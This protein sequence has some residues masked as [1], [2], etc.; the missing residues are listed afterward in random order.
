MNYY[1]GNQRFIIEA[2]I[3]FRTNGSY[4]YLLLQRSVSLLCPEFIYGF[5]I[6]LRINSCYFPNSINQMI[7]VMI[8][9][10]V[11][12]GGKDWILKYYSEG[13]GF[14]G[15]FVSLNPSKGSADTCWK[16]EYVGRYKKYISALK[17]EAVYFFETLIC[18]LK[19]TGRYYPEDQHRQRH[20]RQNLTSHTYRYIGSLIS[21]LSLGW[22]QVL[23]ATSMNISI[24][25]DV[26]PWWWMLF[27]IVSQYL[28]DYMAQHPRRQPSSFRCLCL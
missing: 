24:F 6:N 17:T 22:L 8:I 7:F 18:T 21:P 5:R 9:G 15:L 3:V 2:I 16:R 14:K 27:W 4:M 10:C 25:W 23:T 13:F 11:F 26:S 12:Y 28:P 19:P 1:L 20:R